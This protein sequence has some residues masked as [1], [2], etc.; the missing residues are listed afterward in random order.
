MF[1][2]MGFDFRQFGFWFI[3]LYFL[4]PQHSMIEVGVY[5][6]YPDECLAFSVLHRCAT[7]I[8]KLRGTARFVPFFLFILTLLQLTGMLEVCGHAEI[9]LNLRR[10]FFSCV[11]ISVFLNPSSRDCY[12]LYLLQC[13]WQFY[14]L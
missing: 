1:H 11:L 7:A 14:L 9:L 4:Y 2:F 3:L 10:L 8:S 5:I 12:G 6:K 13:Y